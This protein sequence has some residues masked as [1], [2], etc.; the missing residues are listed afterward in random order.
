MQ[1]RMVYVKRLTYFWKAYFSG[2]IS[3]PSVQGRYLKELLKLWP[4]VNY[5]Y[6][7]KRIPSLRVKKCKKVLDRILI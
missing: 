2:N 5:L 1:Y 6:S 3:D 4:L 7:P